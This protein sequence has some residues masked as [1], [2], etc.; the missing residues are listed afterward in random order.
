MGEAA[1]DHRFSLERG[2]EQLLHRG[3]KSINID[4]DDTPSHPVHLA[5]FLRTISSSF[6]A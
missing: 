5:S 6:S 4:V 1:H 3:K 2:V